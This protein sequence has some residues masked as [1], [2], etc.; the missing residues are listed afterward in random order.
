MSDAAGNAGQ[1]NW[2]LL[3]GTLCTPDV[4]DPLLNNL[5]IGAQR[6]KFIE[7]NRPDVADY[8]SDLTSTITHGDVVCGFSL[9]AIVAVHNLDVLQRASAVILLACNPYADPPENRANRESIRDRVIGGHA[10]DWVHEKAHTMMANVDMALVSTVISMAEET[11]HIIGAQTDLA[12]GRP[13]AVDEILSSS[14][15][16]FFVTGTED[17]MTPAERIRDVTEKS[18]NAVL[19][20]VAGLGHYALIENPAAVADAIR[21]ALDKLKLSRPTERAHAAPK[22]TQLAS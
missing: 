1:S 18:R 19:T 4:F 9:G 3:P 8:R 16:L 6:R 15:P 13:G 5:G 22:H 20:E 21:V 17:Q 14:V 11:S 7:L 10:A 2:V 12:A